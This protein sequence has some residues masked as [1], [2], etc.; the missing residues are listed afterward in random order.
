MV[1]AR[2]RADS[3][4]RVARAQSP[5]GTGGARLVRGNGSPAALLAR[6]LG[7]PAMLPAIASGFGMPSVLLW[8]G[9]GGATHSRAATLRADRGWKPVLLYHLS[10]DGYELG[11]SLPV[12][13]EEAQARW[14]SVRA[15]LEPRA[16]LGEALLPNGADHHAAPARS[17]ARRTRARGCSAPGHAPRASP[18][19]ARDRRR[20]RARGGDRVSRLSAPLASVQGELRDSYGYTWTLQGT[21]GTRSALKRRAAR[22]EQ[23][24]LRN[25][26]PW[27]ALAERARPAVRNAHMRAA[28]KTLLACQ[29]HDTSA[30]V[31]SMPW[32]ARCRRA[33]RRWR[34]S[35]PGCARMRCSTHRLRRDR[36]TRGGERV[37]LARGRVQSA[38]R[39]RGGIA[40]VNVQMVRDHVRVGPGSGGVQ[41]CR[42]ARPRPA[43]RSRV[44]TIPVQI[45]S[46]TR[47]H[48][49]VESPQHYPWDDLVESTAALI[50]VPQSQATGRAR[51]PARAR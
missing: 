22:A 44:G 15:V 28:W 7:H 47:R 16:T 5:R 14:A 6:C 35:R 3:L 2:R 9:Y 36:D 45:L 24:L 21:F 40:A 1:R 12:S 41:E 27:V 33:S 32:L 26:E 50:W 31:R 48:A 18:A 46:S 8:R 37:E 4:G 29:P 43:G 17:R 42:S 38:A 11:A 51:I 19:S 34:R 30:D 39:P 49:R 10:P 20:R 23:S 13:G 25:T